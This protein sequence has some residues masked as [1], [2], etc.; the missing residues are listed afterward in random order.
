MKMA[1]S[2]ARALPENNQQQQ[3]VPEYRQSIFSRPGGDGQPSVDR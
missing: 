1:L 3:A 2:T